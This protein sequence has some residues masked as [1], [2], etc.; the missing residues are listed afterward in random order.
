M[1][2][3]TLQKKTTHIGKKS[4]KLQEVV[5]NVFVIVVSRF[6]VLLGT[7]EQ[8]PKVVRD[9]IFTCVVLHNWLRTRQG[10][11]DRAPTLAN[12]V[13]AL[14]NKQVVYVPNDNYRNPSREAKHQQHLLKYYFNHWGA[15]AGQE[16][17]I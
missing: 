11:A 3:E 8:R 2:G 13:A 6:R 15:L 7:M 10:R 12:D 16:D 9:I 17:R 14:Q 4:S 5:E 1:D